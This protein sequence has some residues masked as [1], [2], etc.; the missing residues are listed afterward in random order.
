M[1]TG[2]GVQLYVNSCS[3]SM[4]NK[5]LAVVLGIRVNTVVANYNTTSLQSNETNEGSRHKTDE[6]FFLS[7]EF[8]SFLKN[9]SILCEGTA[10]QEKFFLVTYH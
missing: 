1:S 2:V 3:D 5:I 6:D 7:E 9:R 4:I 10:T 8:F